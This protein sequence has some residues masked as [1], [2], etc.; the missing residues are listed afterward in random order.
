MFKAQQSSEIWRNELNEQQFKAATHDEG[1]LLIVAG[2]GTGKTKTLAAR[3]SHLLSEGVAPERILLLTFTR[4]ASE[5]MIRRAA[6]AIPD[7]PAVAKRVWGG[8]FHAI[9]NRLLRIFAIPAGLTSDFTIMDRTDSE[10]LLDIVRHDLGFSGLNRRF[11]RKSTCMSIYSRRVNGNEKL[12]AILTRNFPWCQEWGDQLNTLFREYALRKQRSN[13]LDYDDLLL[14]LY[15]LLGDDQVS[16]V[17][18]S[19][20]DHVLVDEYQDTNRLQAGILLRMRRDNKNITVVGDDAQS[21]YSFRSATVQNIL[22]FPDHFPGTKVVTLEQNYRSIQ[23]ILETTNRIIAQAQRRY[24]KELW[25]NNNGGERPKMIT[26]QDET[27]QDEAVIKRVLEHYEEGILLRKQAVLFRASHHSASLEIALARKN[28]PYH[29]YGG[30][31]FLEAA[32]VKDLV[33]ILRILANPRDEIA[34][35]RILQLLDGVGPVTAAS[36]YDH[37]ASNQFDPISIDTAKVPVATREGIATLTQCLAD[38]I[39]MKEADS[40]AVFERVLQ[41]YRPLLEH[42]YDNVAQRI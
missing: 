8:T 4:R 11:P 33:G 32:H 16:E 36:V 25:S 40:L 31:R 13:L 22:D 19:L 10:D 38:I 9:A 35:F 27:Y 26:C 24:A 18:S 3:V 7:G 23:P 15:F 1:P 29:K 12:N 5:E 39:A 30:L 34:W 28:I 17:V 41:F 42:N 6:S 2:A 20:F 37:V 14:Y 21:I